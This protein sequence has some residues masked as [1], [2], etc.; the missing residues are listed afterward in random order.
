[1]TKQGGHPPSPCCRK[2]VIAELISR[3]RV[4]A[5]APGQEAGPGPR[6]A[7]SA[8]QEAKASE[9]ASPGGPAR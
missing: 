2:D 8:A 4:K 5:E 6:L 1:M 9:L 3:P 7:A